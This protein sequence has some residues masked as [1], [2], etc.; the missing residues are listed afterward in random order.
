MITYLGGPVVL[1]NDEMLTLERQ[2][3]FI[4]N[5]NNDNFLSHSLSTVSSSISCH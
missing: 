5:H 1:K 2:W 3:H 4:S